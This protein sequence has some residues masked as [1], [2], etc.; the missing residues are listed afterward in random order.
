MRILIEDMQNCICCK[1]SIPIL[2]EG[3]FPEL[4]T[5]ALGKLEEVFTNFSTT[6]WLQGIC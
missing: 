4:N 3:L 5:Y 6:F 1:R 2:L